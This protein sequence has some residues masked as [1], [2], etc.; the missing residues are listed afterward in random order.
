MTLDQAYYVYIMANKRRTTLYTGKSSDLQI[1]VIEH[2]KKLS[3]K[4]FTARYNIDRLVYYEGFS[5]DEEARQRE[6]QIKA[7]SRIKK[8]ELI[9]QMNP[10]WDDLSNGWDL[11]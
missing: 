3:P 4:S 9:E 8:I 1:R 7:G 10:D 2:K 6:H 11:Y 5:T